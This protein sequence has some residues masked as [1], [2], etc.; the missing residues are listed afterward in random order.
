MAHS[1]TVKEIAEK[2]GISP[3]TIRRYVAEGRIT[4]HRLGPKLIRLDPAQVEQELFGTSK[5]A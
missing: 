3:T 5:S 1:A 2:Y 4:A